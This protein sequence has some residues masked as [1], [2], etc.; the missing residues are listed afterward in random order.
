MKVLAEAFPGSI[1]VFATM[2]Q[3]TEF[4]K[5]EISRIKELAEWGREYDEDRQQT[6]APVITLTGTEL[7]TEYTLEET[8][9]KNGGKYKNLIGPTRRPNDLK[10]LADLT[11]RLYLGMPPYGLP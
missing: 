11:Q 7:F 5:K 9:E 4:S 8:W 1:L 6:R 2:K 3:E 10:V